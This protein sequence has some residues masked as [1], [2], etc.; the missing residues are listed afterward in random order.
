MTDGMNIANER[1]TGDIARQVREEFMPKL[2]VGLGDDDGRIV[3]LAVV[4]AADLGMQ[5]GATEAIASINSWW[6]ALRPEERARLA[7][8][9]LL[10]DQRVWPGESRE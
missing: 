7:G 6:A 9:E 3:A 1:F 8:V 2:S 4:R 10:V 5:R